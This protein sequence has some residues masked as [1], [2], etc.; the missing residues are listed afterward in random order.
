MRLNGIHADPLERN[1][2]ILKGMICGFLKT[3]RIWFS[4]SLSPPLSPPSAPPPLSFPSISKNVSRGGFMARGGKFVI[5][6]EAVGS[7]V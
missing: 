4:L 2:C 1:E 3:A 6:G 7:K 5:K